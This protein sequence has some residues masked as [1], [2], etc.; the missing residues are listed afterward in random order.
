[1]RMINPKEPSVWRQLWIQIAI[2]VPLLTDALALI[3][4][5]L[6]HNFIHDRIDIDLV[7]P[8]RTEISSPRG[9]YSY[10]S[11]TTDIAGRPGVSFGTFSIFPICIR[12]HCGRDHNAVP[13]RSSILNKI[14]F[15][16]PRTRFELVTFAFL[17]SLPRQRSWLVVVSTRLSHRGIR[18]WSRFS[19]AI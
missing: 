6:V 18:E 14:E 8:A 3:T 9:A 1:M 19:R 5:T 4:L 7:G 13:I 10:Y 15:V 12:N 17:R 2:M 11:G 16:E